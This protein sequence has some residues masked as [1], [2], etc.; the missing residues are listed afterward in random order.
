MFVLEGVKNTN[1]VVLLSF[2]YYISER[3]FRSEF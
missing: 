1:G 3:F 2:R